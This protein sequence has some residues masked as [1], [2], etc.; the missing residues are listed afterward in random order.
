MALIW[1]AQGSRVCS[2]QWVGYSL[3]MTSSQGWGIAQARVS[4][5]RVG[6]LASTGDQTED[7]GQMVN[8]RA[9]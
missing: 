5:Y 3:Q 7:I 2:L 9:R 4:R 1:R 8:D 6:A